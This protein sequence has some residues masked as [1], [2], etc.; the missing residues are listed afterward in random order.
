MNE[1]HGL[2]E[3]FGSIFGALIFIA[4]PGIGIGFLWKWAL[5]SDSMTPV[6]INTSI[7][8]LIAIIYGGFVGLLPSRNAR[9]G[10]NF[11]LMPLLVIV[12]HIIVPVIA[13][14]IKIF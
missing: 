3:I 12:C 1:E 6:M 13:V 5:G 11:M 10:A 9:Q 2:P 14:I 4:I 7:Y 8:V